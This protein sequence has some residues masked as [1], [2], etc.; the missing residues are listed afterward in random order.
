M[1]GKGQMPYYKGDHFQKPMW[2]PEVIEDFDS[3]MDGIRK[4]FPFMEDL[5]NVYTIM[6]L[7][8]II[9]FVIILVIDGIIY[10]KL[11]II[12]IIIITFISQY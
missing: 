1:V 6:T 8:I 9:I 11:I 3:K 2:S 5:F 10:Y 12:F 7:I 4:F